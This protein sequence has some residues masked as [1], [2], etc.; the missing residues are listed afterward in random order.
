VISLG[1]WFQD[2][3]TEF[4]TLVRKTL[5]E[6]KP[7]FVYMHPI[8]DT[9]L[10]GCITQFVKYEVGSE[11]GVA[12][13]LA[14]TLLEDKEFPSEIN[15]ILEEF[16]IGYLSAES[17]VGEEELESMYETIDEKT[18]LSLI[19]GSDL[20]THP[21]AGQIAKLIA[22]LEIYAGVNVVCIPPAKNA[23]GVALICDL[24]DV[25]QGQSVVYESCKE[26]TYVDADK[27][28]YMH[29]E[30]QPSGVEGLNS[31]AKSLG[32]HEDTLM[33]YSNQ[34]PQNKG[35]KVLSNG[36]KDCMYK[37]V[38][39]ERKKEILVDEIDD[40]PVYDGA[41]IYTYKV[42][43]STV[44]MERKVHELYG[45]KQFAMATKLQDGELISFE[46]GGDKLRRVFRIDTHLKGVIALNPVFD[47]K[48]SA[49]LLSSYRFS[50]LAFE[51]IQ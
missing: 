5:D 48:L 13:L 4:T 29:D 21:K 14:Y 33:D 17:N 28:V 47:I 46:L 19:I 16:D 43:E 20:Y 44:E 7:K 30:M 23:L 49:Y 32:L 3:S 27:C 25:I 34:L 6:K 1:V 42:E 37:V 11:E 15:D 36:P 22:F 24:D 50:R 9:A 41:L 31:I 2:E 39:Q 12:A 40:L 35:F 10:Q 45:S 26:G 8:E 38:P 51:K 18:T